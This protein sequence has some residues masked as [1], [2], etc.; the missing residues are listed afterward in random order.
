MKRL[1]LMLLAMLL[2]ASGLGLAAY[3]IQVLGFPLT[4]EERVAIWIVEARLGFEATGGSVKATLAIP[5][6]PPGFEILDENFVSRGYGLTTGTEGDNRVAVWTARRPSGR[7]A[8]YYRV[9]LYRSR[10]G[11]LRGPMPPLPPVPD[12]GEPERS[13]VMAVLDDVRARSADIATFA[14][15]LVQY[16]N[17]PAPSENVQLL[18]P[19]GASGTE[20]ARLAISMLAGARIPA[21]MAHAV[22]LVDGARDAQTE[23]WLEVHN[24]TQWVPINPT[25]GLRGYPDTVAVWWRGEEPP[26]TITRARNAG[27]GFSVTRGMRASLDTAAERAQRA[28]P[29]V[30]DYS[31]LGLPVQMQNLYRVLLLVP[32]GALVMVFLRNVVGIQTFGTFMPVLIALS[33]RETELVAGLVL[34]TVIV[35]LGLAI[36]F[37]LEHLKLLLVPRL[38][39]VVIVVI[40]LMALLSILAHRLRLEL[41]LS[42]ALFPMIILA[43]TIE[44]MSIVWEE[45]GAAEAIRQGIGSLVV[46]T[47]CYLLLFSRP[48]EHLVFVFPELLLVVLAATLLLGRYTGYRLTELVRFRALGER[49]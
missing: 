9:M 12:Y 39:S 18:L 45:L 44:R 1:H 32:L 25:T 47:L 22:Q 19:R 10:D 23:A 34:F 4:T 43:M 6:D 46:A 42:V 2:A 15:V 21:R 36:R 5:D 41:G 48:V 3:K 11:E 14:S 8:L 20:K 33:F 27:L 24:G 26:F 30:V 38:A 40:L 31:L 35:A 7:Q 49:R 13:A 37:Y 29:A 28:H 17:S 16:L